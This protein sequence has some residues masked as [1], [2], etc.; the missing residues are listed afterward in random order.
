MLN[1]AQVTLDKVHASTSLESFLYLACNLDQIR[2]WVIVTDKHR[3]PMHQTAIVNDHPIT[4]FQL[5]PLH[6]DGHICG[7]QQWSATAYTTQGQESSKL[8]FYKSE[9]PHELL[10]TA[11]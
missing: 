4:D 2:T 5:V 11:R 6:A 8:V 1:C 3:N 9:S 7:S 10:E